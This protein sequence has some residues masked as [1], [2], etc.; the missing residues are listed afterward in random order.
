MGTRLWWGEQK[1]LLALSYSAFDALISA[2][3]DGMRL[4]KQRANNCC[5]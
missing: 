5:D 4:E 3:A 2:A 1:H